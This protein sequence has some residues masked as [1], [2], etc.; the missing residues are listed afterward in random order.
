ML[1]NVKYTL[2]MSQDI[3]YLS[4]DEVGAYTTAFSNN[5]CWYRMLL[6]MARTKY[7]RKTSVCL[8]GNV[9]RPLNISSNC[10]NA[11]HI[12]GILKFRRSHL[13]Y[14][15]DTDGMQLNIKK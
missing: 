9:P 1:S 2:V 7:C 15:G 3:V 5:A 4:R 6:C 13:A 14:N 10:F 11:P 8:S 12:N